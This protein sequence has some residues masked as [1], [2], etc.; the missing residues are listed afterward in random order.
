MAQTVNPFVAAYNAAV[1]NGVHPEVKA[2][3]TESAE[4]TKLVA[5]I[6]GGHPTAVA[7]NARLVA[8]RTAIAN[9]I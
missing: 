4:L 5:L 8:I 9:H 3:L 6:S 2:L 1:A 7:A